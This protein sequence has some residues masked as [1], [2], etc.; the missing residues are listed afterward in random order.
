LLRTQPALHL[1]LGGFDNA[2]VPF[3]PGQPFDRNKEL[4]II[5]F[6]RVHNS[7]SE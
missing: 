1:A 4:R 6:L 2:G 5:L 3:N 7:S